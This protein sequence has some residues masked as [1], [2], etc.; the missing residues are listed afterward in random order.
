MKLL[1]PRSTSEHTRFLSLT[2]D[3]L[4]HENII[5]F[6]KFLFHKIKCF[7]ITQVMLCYINEVRLVVLFFLGLGLEEIVIL[8]T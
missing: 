6:L 4:S 7:K 3:V 8:W 1:R 2:I 5:L